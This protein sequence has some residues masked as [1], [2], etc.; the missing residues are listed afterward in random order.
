M[1]PPQY[2]PDSSP[3][4]WYATGP[5]ICSVVATVPFSGTA[6]VVQLATSWSAPELVHRR[7]MF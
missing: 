6:P 3:V 7:V 4:T 5:G 2:C 1:A